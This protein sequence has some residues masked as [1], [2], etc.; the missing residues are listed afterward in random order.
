MTPMSS[1]LLS[2]TTRPESSSAIFE[3]ATPITTLRSVRRIALKSIHWVPSNSTSPEICAS[4]GGRSQRVIFFR[5]DRPLT[6]LSQTVSLS[7]PMGL[8]MPR[9]VTATR[10]V[11]SALLIPMA[12][13]G[14]SCRAGGEEVGD[15]QSARRRLLVEREGLGIRCSALDEAGQ[16]LARSDLD[17]LADARGGHCLNR[18]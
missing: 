4:Y 15:R 16:D 11:N 8:M 3:E 10:R 12:L 2:S 13:A 1:R 9:P 5:P 14:C 7:W 17:E 6:R 18:G